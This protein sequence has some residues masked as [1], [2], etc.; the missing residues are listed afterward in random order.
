[1]RISAKLR[2]LEIEEPAPEETDPEK[3]IVAAALTLLKQRLKMGKLQ[4]GVEVNIYQTKEEAVNSV[5][6]NK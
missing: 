4:T 2:V 6:K 1:M 3:K 5:Q